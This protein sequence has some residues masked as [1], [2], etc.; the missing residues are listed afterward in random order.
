MPT[1]YAYLNGR[2]VPEQQAAISPLDIGLLRGYAV[3]DLLR[4]VAGRPFLFA[5]HLQRLH[6]SAAQLGLAVPASDDEIA[7]AVADLLARNNHVEATVRLVLTGGVSP[8][9]MA[10][11][12]TTPTFLI[13]THELHE[14]PAEVYERGAKLLT[15][16]HEREMP[17]AKTTDYLTMLANRP[18]VAAEGALDLLYHSGG[19]ITEAASASFYIVTEGT[20]R[21]SAERRASRHCGD[22]RTRAG[23]RGLPRGDRE[24]TLE[25]AYS[26]QEAFLTSTTRGVVPIVALD[27]RAVGSGE[28][29]PI[30]TDWSPATQRRSTRS[31]S[32]ARALLDRGDLT[33]LAVDPHLLHALGAGARDEGERPVA[34]RLVL[35]AGDLD[36]ADAHHHVGRREAVPLLQVCLARLVC[37]FRPHLH[38][39]DRHRRGLDDLRRVE[40]RQSSGAEALPCSTGT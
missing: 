31:A 23:A 5:E 38:R 12:P 24:I 9:G 37:L 20:N 8:D 30:V 21:R 16:E 1:R 28:V 26:A 18:R 10:F 34:G 40:G 35:Q 25:D 2:I 22:V 3:F 39:A 19:R 11:D 27:N 7:E 29:G 4:T 33:G 6:D 13:L 17:L 32:L 36:E 15:E 14:P